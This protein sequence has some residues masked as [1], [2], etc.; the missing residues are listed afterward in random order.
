MTKLIKKDLVL[1]NMGNINFVGIIGD[2]ISSQKA[3]IQPIDNYADD[4]FNKNTL[5]YVSRKYMK[6]I[7]KLEYINNNLIV[8][9]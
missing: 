4:I 8:F 1:F 9:D 6:K 5:V 7:N 2:L 3:Q